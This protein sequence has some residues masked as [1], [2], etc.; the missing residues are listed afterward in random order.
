MVAFALLPFVAVLLIHRSIPSLEDISRFF[1]NV[2]PTI[3]PD[4]L[5][6]MIQGTIL[7]INGAIYMALIIV[8]SALLFDVEWRGR[9]II[10][11]RTPL[12]VYL[13]YFLTV[14]LLFSMFASEIL[15]MWDEALWGTARAPTLTLVV[16]L[17]GLTILGARILS[18]IPIKVEDTNLGSFIVVIYISYAIFKILSQGFNPVS[19]WVRVLHTE[20]IPSYANAFFLLS[21]P[22][23][24][25][26]VL[27]LLDMFI[28]RRVGDGK[29]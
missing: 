20:L 13:G 6:A 11:S 18:K 9:K 26:F 24:L 8:G 3:V 21:L 25:A 15:Q 14:A 22:A 1:A 5:N 7:F 2:R 28:I 10:Q 16:I 17:L 23:I 27:M 4:V 29:L 12:H 19:L